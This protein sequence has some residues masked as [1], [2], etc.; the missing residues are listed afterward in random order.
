MLPIYKE[1]SSGDDPSSVIIWGGYSELDHVNG[2]NLAQYGDEHGDFLSQYRNRL[3]RW[4]PG[5]NV[6]KKLV[7]TSDVLPKAQSFAAEIK[8]DT[9][10]VHLLIGG[11][12]GFTGESMTENKNFLGETM[13]TP[14]SS[15]KGEKKSEY[16]LL[17]FIF[18]KAHLYLLSHYLLC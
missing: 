16:L 10:S 9:K 4:Y 2:P 5:S 3:L 17:R 15:N 6:W 1:R 7:Q 13:G 12:Y 18:F 8:S 11:G 14:M